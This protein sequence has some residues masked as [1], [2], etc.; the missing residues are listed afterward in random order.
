MVSCTRQILH[1]AAPD[2]DNA[3]L[4][5]I[6]AFTG[7]I[8]CHFNPVGKTYPGDL[9]KGSVRL[10][11]GRG[12]NSSTNTSLLRR[13]SIGRFLVKRIPSSLESGSR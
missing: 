5:Q 3:M 8:T 12:L 11:G 2:E 9:P 1:P 6:V 4:L 10:L 13:R 7:D